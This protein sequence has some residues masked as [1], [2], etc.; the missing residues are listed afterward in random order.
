V[1]NVKRQKF[2]KSDLSMLIQEV[3]MESNK[4]RIKRNDFAKVANNLGVMPI[5]A[6]KEGR[7]IVLRQ[8]E[9]RSEIKHGN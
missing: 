4:I 7:K 2:K 9:Y 5:L 8:V 6:F 1:E 3:K